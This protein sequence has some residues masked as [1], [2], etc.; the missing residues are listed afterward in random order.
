MLAKSPGK[1]WL[2]LG[3]NS[4]TDDKDKK[5]RQIRKICDFSQ[6]AI[7]TARF[8]ETDNAEP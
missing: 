3:K 1:R 8:R 5:K 2:L 7:C 4:K 6:S